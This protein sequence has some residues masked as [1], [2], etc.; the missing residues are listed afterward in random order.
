MHI[1]KCASSAVRFSIT[2]EEGWNY[3][4]RWIIHGGVIEIKDDWLTPLTTATMTYVR[5]VMRENVVFIIH[6]I[7]LLVRCARGFALHFDV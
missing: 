1:L 6:R 7:C 4:R 3:E 2:M 5:Q